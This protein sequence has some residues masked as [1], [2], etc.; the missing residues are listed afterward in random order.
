MRRHPSL[1]LIRLDIPQ[2]TV[3]GSTA[4]LAWVGGLGTLAG[5]GA[6]GG[7]SLSLEVS[8]DEG[9]TYFAVGTDTT[10]TADGHG[11]F[12]LPHG[13]LLRGTLSGSTGPNILVEILPRRPFA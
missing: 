1:T 7:G 9:T 2:L 4:V 3:D 13:V 8:Y 6:F 11:N 10:I 12:D 5:Y